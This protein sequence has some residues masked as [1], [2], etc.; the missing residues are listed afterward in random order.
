MK[1]EKTSGGRGM[2]ATRKV[3]MDSEVSDM[4]FKESGVTREEGGG[5]AQK[6]QW[7]ARLTRHRSILSISDQKDNKKK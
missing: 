5:T 3:M 7:G 6:W 1:E 2:R 4:H